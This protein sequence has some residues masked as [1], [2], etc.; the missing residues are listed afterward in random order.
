M[1]SQ[2]S[3][4]LSQP[5]SSSASTQ[6]KQQSISSFFSAKPPAAAKPKPLQRNPPSTLQP[7]SLQRN[8]TTE[9]NEL[10]VSDKEDE[11]EG[12]LPR[13]GSAWLKRVLEDEEDGDDLP[14]PKRFRH[15][16]EEKHE[17]AVKEDPEPKS[18]PRTSTLPQAADHINGS[19]QT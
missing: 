13:R 9:S 12:V 1:V 3:P 5:P 10:F 2:R 6:K 14:N 8:E 17:E 16:V 11:E 15:A 7:E 4:S 19:G 18:P